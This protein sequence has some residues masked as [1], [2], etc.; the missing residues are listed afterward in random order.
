M[1]EDNDICERQQLGLRAQKAVPGRFCKHEI[2]AWKFDNWVARM[3]YE[4]HPS[5]G[6]GAVQ[7]ARA[8]AEFIR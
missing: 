8:A 7:P 1:A 4:D 5:N 3:A 6:S 2:L